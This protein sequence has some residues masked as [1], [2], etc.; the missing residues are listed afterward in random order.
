MTLHS[1]PWDQFTFEEAPFYCIDLHLVERACPRL[2]LSDLPFLL[3]VVFD[4]SLRRAD[5]PSQLA[6]VFSAAAAWRARGA[7]ADQV[8]IY[9]TRIL[10]QDYTGIPV[11]V[12]L[13][14]LRSIFIHE[15]GV[16]C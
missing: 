12:D 5:S 4:R 2:R 13:G 6:Q 15:S 10:L 11:L 8:S 14:S 9:P 7:S 16:L 1:V 3:R